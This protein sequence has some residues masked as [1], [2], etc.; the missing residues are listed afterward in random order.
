MATETSVRILKLPE[1]EAKS[2]LSSTSIYR[3]SRAGWFPKPV[4]ISLG[5][6][7]W[8]EAEVNDYLAKR[9]AERDAS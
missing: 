9:I 8:V 4:K 3:G 2:G 7:G 6:T 1:V 5:A